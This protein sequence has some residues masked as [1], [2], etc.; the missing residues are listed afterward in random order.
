MVL[1]GWP[2]NEAAIS[3]RKLHDVWGT[4]RPRAWFCLGISA[5]RGSILCELVFAILGIVRIRVAGAAW[6]EGRILASHLGWQRK[7][8]LV[9][10]VTP[11]RLC[12][13]LSCL[14]Y[15]DVWPGLSGAGPLGDVRQRVSG[16]QASVGFKNPPKQELVVLFGIVLADESLWPLTNS[17]CQE[18]SKIVANFLSFFCLQESLH[19]NEGAI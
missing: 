18:A 15:I 4:Y 1:R 9:A 5:P 12:W 10:L 11:S 17:P 13:P 14:P 19:C 16:P 6:L 7:S 3:T 2:I 8:N